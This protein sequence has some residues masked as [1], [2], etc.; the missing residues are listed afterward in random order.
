MDALILS[1]LENFPTVGLIL[2]I[3][4][5]L[6]TLS[7]GADILV[8]EAVLLSIRWGIPKI[9]IGATI[10]SLGTTLP[11]ATVS[12]FAAMRGNPDLALGNAIGSIIANTG[13]IIGLAALI[14][15]LPVDRV[16]VE[17][18][19]KIKI[20]VGFLLAFVSLPFLSKGPGGNISQLVGFIF[21]GLLVL[22]IYFL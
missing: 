17:R 7:K 11:E 21:V 2:V 15:K 1:F 4:A 5:M 20:F 12:V 13:L 10:V 19:G 9:V 22:Y 14:G 16:V 8:D 6:Y 3:A 18:Q